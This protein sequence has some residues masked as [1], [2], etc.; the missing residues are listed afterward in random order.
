MHPVGEAGRAIKDGQRAVN[1]VLSYPVL[2]RQ[3]SL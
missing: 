2:G 1:P 3:V